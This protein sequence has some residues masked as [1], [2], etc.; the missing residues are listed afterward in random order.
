MEL[1]TEST[2]T[3]IDDK[4]E[5]FCENPT[6]DTLAEGLMCLLKPTI[7]QLDE[8]VRATRISQVELKQQIEGLAEELRK[9]SDSQQCP[10]DLDAYVKKLMTA[11]Q[12][13]TVVSNILQTAQDRLNK[14]H[15][16]IEKESARRRALLDPTPSTSPLEA[17]NPSIQ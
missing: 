14:V 9:I 15:L 5:D 8:R 11:K 13:V 4:T 10:L 3:S 7:D 6:R 17:T 1:D 2:T 12:K 16:L